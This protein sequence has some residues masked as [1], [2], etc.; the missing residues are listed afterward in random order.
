MCTFYSKLSSMLH[1]V[2]LLQF[3]FS[4]ITFDLIELQKWFMES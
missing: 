2:S 4:A 3:F 1:V